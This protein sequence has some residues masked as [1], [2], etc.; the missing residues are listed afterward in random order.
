MRLTYA[1][2][3]A[4]LRRAQ[5]RFTRAVSAT[6]GELVGVD[7]RFHP[8]R[9]HLG[10]EY[11]DDFA[12]IGPELCIP[13]V[14]GLGKILRILRAARLA[15]PREPVELLGQS[16]LISELLERAVGTPL[17]LRLRPRSRIS[18]SAWTEEG[19][20]VF[21]DVRE[22]IET[23]DDYLVMRK[24]GRP[25]ARVSRAGVVRRQTTCERWFE[26]VEIER[27]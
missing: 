1:R 23:P 13:A 22:V 26:I 2:G 6:R 7:L 14:T 12:P 11:L 27:A 15:S 8:L 24:W 25:P 10:V 19:L 3:V 20:E 9:S 4:H 17:A 18:F 21:E 5:A 16:E